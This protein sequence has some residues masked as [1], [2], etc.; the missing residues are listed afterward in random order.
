MKIA[1]KELAIF[2]YSSGINDEYL[3]DR[4]LDFLDIKLRVLQNFNKVSIS[5]SNLEECILIL[6]ELYPSLLVNISKNV[7][8]IIALRGGFTSHSAILCRMMGIPFVIAEIQDDFDGMVIIDNDTVYLNPTS[9]LLERYSN[10]EVEEQAFNRDLKHVK[11]YANVVDNEEIKN[12]SDDFSGI[13]LYRTEFIIM[14]KEY[15][16]DWEKQAKVYLEALKLS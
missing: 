5:L 8:G 3:K 2:L 12:L 4:Y 1:V 15:A 6:E 16:F 11:V 10:P 9:E 14:D 13:G 7:K